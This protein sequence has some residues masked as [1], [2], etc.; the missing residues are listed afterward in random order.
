MTFQQRQELFWDGNRPINNSTS[1]GPA[2]EPSSYNSL[3][4]LHLD[5]TGL[6][7]L[8]NNTRR[9]CGGGGVTVLGWRFR[10]SVS[11]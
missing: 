10:I 8:P 7:L 9:N 11:K 4:W 2:L 6:W 5:N 1:L 3:R